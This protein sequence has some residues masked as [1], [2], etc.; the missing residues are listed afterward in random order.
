MKGPSSYR[1]YRLVTVKTQIDHF[2]RPVY[3][4]SLDQFTVLFIFLA[5][6]RGKASFLIL[7]LHSHNYNFI[8]PLTG[9][10]RAP[11]GE[12]VSLKEQLY[13]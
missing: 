6:R 9:A 3:A 7:L 11:L 8:Q 4:V 5:I 13:A 1:H 10:V 12:A 2:F